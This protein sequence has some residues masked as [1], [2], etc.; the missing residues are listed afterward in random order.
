MKIN[1]ILAA[2]AFITGISAIFTHHADRNNLYPTWKYKTDRIE[3]EKIRLISVDNLADLVYQK[4]Q[5]MTILDVRTDVEYEQYH[6]P[7]AILYNEQDLLSALNS[8]DKVI[9]YGK[10]DYPYLSEIPNKFS[11]K[12]YNLNGGI[13]EWFSIVLF[14]DFS[15]VQVRNR[16]LLEKIINR[17]RY[18]GGK[19]QNID[20]LNI[21]ARSSRFREGC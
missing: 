2:L 21:S 17:S 13:E 6:I 4:E 16:Q 1:N 15:S 12:I 10:K 9:L 8:S 20:S 14:P 11:G 5:G 18:F 3:K 19:P 7:T